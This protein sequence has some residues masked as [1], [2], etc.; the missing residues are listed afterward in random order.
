MG[1]TLTC[2]VKPSA[3][4]K[5]GRRSGPAEPDYESEVYEAAAGDAVAVAPS[6]A[7]VEPAELDFGTGEGHHLQH[8]SD[9]EMPDGKE[10]AGGGCSRADLW[11]PPPPG[12]PGREPPPR[13]P[14]C[15]EPAF[16]GWA[17]GGGG[18][19]LALPGIP[20]PYSFP[21]LSRPLLSLSTTERPV[22]S[23]VPIPRP[24][25]GPSGPPPCLFVALFNVWWDFVK[26][27]GYIF[28]VCSV[29]TL[30]P[31]LRSL[32]PVSLSLPIQ[33]VPEGRQ[34]PR[35]RCYPRLPPLGS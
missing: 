31:Q 33:T 16:P 9:R 26:T 34:R 29:K 13:A 28:S 11:P 30:I 17:R 7:A 23:P 14:S 4:P 2:C 18:G 20:T 24:S 6:P 5:L 25:L 19:R 1:N 15:P 3:S 10:A 27:F 32:H 22:R 35:A 8:I 21:V 12:S